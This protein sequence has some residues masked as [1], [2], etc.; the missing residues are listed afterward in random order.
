MLSHGAQCS[1]QVGCA[2]SSSRHSG[3]SSVPCR[4]G[5]R[6]RQTQPMLSRALG[7]TSGCLLTHACVGHQGQSSGLG[8]R[9]STAAQ[10]ALSIPWCG[11]TGSGGS[12]SPVLVGRRSGDRLCE[13]PVS[14]TEGGA[15]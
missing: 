14:T 11:L 3:T 2:G 8:R 15:Q 12:G 9:P 13:F 5:R 6:T 1:G 10:C 4:A 7:D